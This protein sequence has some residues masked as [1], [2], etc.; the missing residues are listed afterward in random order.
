VANKVLLE[1]ITP[2]KLFYK[3][4]V[5]SVIVT[6]LDGEEGFMAKHTWACKLL[7]DGKLRIKE[8]GQSDFKIAKIHGG[9]ADIKDTFVIFTDYAKWIEE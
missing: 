9:F 4:E 6:T 8:P 1:V 5:E 3:G 7:G 2:E